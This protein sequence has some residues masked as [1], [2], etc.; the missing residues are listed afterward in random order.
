M[1]LCL[2][3][4]LVGFIVCKGGKCIEDPVKACDDG[5]KWPFI[6]FDAVIVAKNWDGNLFWI[7]RPLCGA[8]RV[9]GV[10][11]DLWNNKN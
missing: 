1:R 8:Y 5:S 10:T 6:S 9:I 2:S 3:G 7:K 11:I 4:N